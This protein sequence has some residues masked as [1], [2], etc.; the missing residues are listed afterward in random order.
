VEM[1]KPLVRSCR[2][3]SRRVLDPFMGSMCSKMPNPEDPCSAWLTV[4]DFCD[5]G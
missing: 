2:G 3:I 1:T 5:L 4:R